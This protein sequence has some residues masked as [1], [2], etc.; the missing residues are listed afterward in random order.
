MDANVGSYI[1]VPQAE[2]I[3][4]KFLASSSQAAHA[5]AH[6]TTLVVQVGNN[7]DGKGSGSKKAMSTMAGRWDSQSNAMMY[8]IDNKTVKKT[9]L[10]KAIAGVFGEKEVG[11]AEDLQV[12]TGYIMKGTTGGSKYYSVATGTELWD[13]IKQFL[14]DWMNPWYG[15]K[16][17]TKAVVVWVVILLVLF[18]AMRRG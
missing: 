13:R 5:K 10:K 6:G 9:D 15:K 1:S 2:D 7:L 11:A 8:M 16:T 17:N 4:Y 14:N 18:F 3:A 12:M